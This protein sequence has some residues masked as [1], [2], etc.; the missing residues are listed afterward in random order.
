MSHS[1]IQVSRKTKAALMNHVLRAYTLVA[2]NEPVYAAENYEY[3]YDHDAARFILLHD[4]NSNF[5]S[6]AQK[7]FDNLNK[8][9]T[10]KYTWDGT[11]MEK[12]HAMEIQH[13]IKMLVE[14]GYLDDVRWAQATFT[15]F[16][17]LGYYL[18][19]RRNLWSSRAQ[20]SKEVYTFEELVPTRSVDSG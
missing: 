7:R 14:T 8:A 3:M 9:M 18:N 1:I 15:S 6:A 13:V 17:H 11:K 19:D 12:D 2:A 4:K 10:Y 20:S 16:L 5:L